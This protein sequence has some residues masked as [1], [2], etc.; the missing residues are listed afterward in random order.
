MNE[1]MNSMTKA[2]VL[3]VGVNLV[4]DCGNDNAATLQIQESQMS[5]LKD[6]MGNCHVPFPL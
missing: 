1:D 6:S 2:C 5:C 4:Q 3:L